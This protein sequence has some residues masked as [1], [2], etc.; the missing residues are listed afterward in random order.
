MGCLQSGDV[1]L[2]RDPAF[3]K[4]G[5][6]AVQAFLCWGI[7]HGG[8]AI[9]PAEFRPDGPLRSKKP[10]LVPGKKYMLHAVLTGIKVWDL[11]SYLQKMA[12]GKPAG[13][14][15]ARHLQISGLDGPVKRSS[16]VAAMDTVF[17]EIC[18]K[19]YEGNISSMLTGYCDT[20]EQLC[21]CCKSHGDDNDLYCSELMARVYITG[22]VLPRERP[23]DEFSPT[24]FLDSDGV[25]IEK[26]SF[27]VGFSLGPIEAL[28]LLDED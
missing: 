19:S 22:G 10:D 1:L 23:A 17:G 5:A 25:T 20:C 6:C 4:A 9:D 24:D 21:P 16:F 27:N 28:P 13:A 2:T 11:E 14:I 7:N 3:G 12:K 15:Y 18:E 26:T 8:L